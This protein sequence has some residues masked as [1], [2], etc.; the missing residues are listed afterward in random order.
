MGQLDQTV[1]FYTNGYV[2]AETGRQKDSIS[3][4]GK[5]FHFYDLFR[6]V[7]TKTTDLE[8]SVGT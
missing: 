1:N 4:L 2:I 3:E 6:T 8:L 5:S 7:G